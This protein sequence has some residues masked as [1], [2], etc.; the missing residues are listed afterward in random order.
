MNDE[1]YDIDQDEPTAE[2]RLAADAVRALPTP[3]ASSDFRATLRGQFVTGAFEAESE[4]EARTVRRA[5]RPRPR[6]KAWAVPLALAASLAILVGVLNRGS[7]WSIVSTGGD[8]VLVDGRA[9]PCDDLSPLQAALRPGCRIE[10]PDGGQLEVVADALAL[11]INGGMDVTLPSAP[12]KWFFR[13]VASQV[14]GDGTL[15]VATGD[16]FHGATYRLQTGPAELVVTGTAFSVMSNP[17]YVCICVLEGGIAASL[18]DGT[19]REIPSGGRLTV[20]RGD[21]SFDEGAMHDVERSALAQ[22]KTRVT[23]P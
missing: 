11:Q 2:Q 3:E 14:G 17:D 10:V 20:Q 12:G 18:P 5:L 16:D 22:L 19:I 9:M 1:T 7:E 8:H 6:K 23:S 15:R 21:G 13:D 4:A